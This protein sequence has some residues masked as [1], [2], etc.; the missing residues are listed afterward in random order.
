[1]GS[2]IWAERYDGELAQIFDLQ[3][4]VA[5]DVVGAIA[6]RVEQA[7][8]DRAKRNPTTSLNAYGHYLR[9]MAFLPPSNLDAEIEARRLMLK[10]IDLD[11]DYAVPHA[12]PG[13]ARR[14]APAKLDRNNRVVTHVQ[15]QGRRTYLLICSSSFAPPAPHWQP[16]S[17]VS[18]IIATNEASPA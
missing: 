10:S 6:P 1:M 9:G 2:H 13:N 12:R 11:P 16:R 3:D 4:K 5:T 15:Y 14:H 18:V 17:T 8:I 7:E